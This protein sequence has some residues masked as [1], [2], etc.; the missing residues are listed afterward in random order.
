MKN[1][2][3]RILTINSGSSSLKFALY[4][5]ARKEEQE[6]SGSFERIGLRGG[7]A[8][9]RGIQDEKVIDQHVNLP[10]HESALKMLFDW[11]AS[12]A[13]CDQLDA[14]GHRI[15]HGGHEFKRPQLVTSELVA[16]LKNL[17]PMASEHLP[18]EIASIQSLKKICPDTPQVACFDTA[19]H[20]FM[21]EIAQ[22]YPL[23][24]HYHLQGLVRYGF[25]GLSYEYIMG[26]LKKQAGMAAAK[27][28]VIIAHLGNGASMVAVRGGRS[29]DTSMGFTPSGGLV[30]GTRSGDLDPG[31]LLY[32]LE[33]VGFSP[34]TLSDLVNR[35][36]GLLG[37]SGISSSMKDLLEKR[38]KYPS[39][40]RAIDLFC[41][42]AKKY[43]GALTTVLGGLDTLI[44]TGGIGENVPEVR[45][46]ICQDLEYLGIWCDPKN[47][48]EN[49][50]II[51][52]E[53]SPVVVRV[54][55]TN[56]QLMI[57]RHTANLIREK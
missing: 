48:Q 13:T 4:R 22:T 21:P 15:V 25:H 39:A 41:Y 40:R 44:F 54:M 32:L 51:S 30:M 6:Y 34:S 57:A 49:A 56:E 11:L 19:F 55:K 52:S 53:A 1:I 50:A 27:G 12:S 24:Y 7:L 14:V 33:E 45:R 42:Q 36:A 9:I 20:R 37:V 38:G 28:R 8:H 46:Q 10:D 35:E 2:P 18:H 23:P 17:I 47:N 16:T 5:I 43:L 29:L 26:E 31:V 3:L